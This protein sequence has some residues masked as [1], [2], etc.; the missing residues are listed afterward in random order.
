MLLNSIL[1]LNKF[2]MEEWLK[3]AI[4]FLSYIISII[5]L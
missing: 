5:Y 2:L 4:L 1:K 3:V